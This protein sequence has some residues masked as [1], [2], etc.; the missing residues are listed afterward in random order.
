MSLLA[1]ETIAQRIEPVAMWKDLVL[2]E[3]QREKL[4]QIA[5]EVKRHLRR[6]SEADSEGESRARSGIM[7]LF[8]GESGTGKTAASQVL[9]NEL[10]LD[11][12]RI[13]LSRVVN[14]YNGETEKNLK[15]IFYAAQDGGA[16]LL[17]DEADALFGK[18]SKVKDSHDRYSNIEINYFLHRIDTY[19]GLTIINT[20]M[21]GPD[22]GHLHLSPVATVLFS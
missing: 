2:P 15:R 3:E 18:R 11:L 13:Q 1:L 17:F 19:R 10:K 4:K 6:H 14:K 9:A 21:N 12:Y 8:A 22:L 16:I 20:N 5:D 7:A